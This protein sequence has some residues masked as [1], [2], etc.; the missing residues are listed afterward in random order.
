MAHPFNCHW[1]LHDDSKNKKVKNCLLLI[2]ILFV[3]CALF[4]ASALAKSG[5]VNIPILSPLLFKEPVEL[6]KPDLSAKE[7]ISKKLK[8]IEKKVDKEIE[9]PLTQEEILGLVISASEKSNIPIQRL[10]IVIYKDKVEAWGKW[11][12]VWL[13][14]SFLPLAVGEKVQFEVKQI[15]IGSLTVPYLF[16]DKV[17]GLVITKTKIPLS[18]EI[19]GIR[20]LELGEGRV[21]IKT[22]KDFLPQFESQILK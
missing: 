2:L 8:E 6:V 4:V 9:L 15:Q 14:G 5:L 10:Q 19:K 17:L 22:S 1:S 16:T 7:S 13:R 12:N 18:Y 21:I 3:L 20:S 11:N